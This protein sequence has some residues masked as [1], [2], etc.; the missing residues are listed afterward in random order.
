[1]NPLATFPYPSYP[2]SPVHFPPFPKFN[3]LFM[4]ILF[5][6]PATI[7][8]YVHL[9]VVHQH[10]TKNQIMEFQ[11]LTYLKILHFWALFAFSVEIVKNLQI[12]LI[13]FLRFF[14]LLD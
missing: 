10:F 13:D 3:S 12:F 8:L 4:V 6:P 5:N 2:P 11:N 14:P 9:S 7:H 1:M